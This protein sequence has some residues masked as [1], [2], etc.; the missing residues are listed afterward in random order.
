[1]LFFALLAASCTD[2]KSETAELHWT[3][4]GETGPEHWGNLE[5]EYALCET[6]LQQSPVNFNN[7]TANNALPILTFDYHAASGTLRSNGHAL[8]FDYP[9]GSKV[10][11][12]STDYTLK[13]FHFHTP[14]EHGLGLIAWPLE[15]HLV[16]QHADGKLVVVGVLFHESETES[17]FL[18]QF[19][20]KIE[21]ASL[22]VEVD[23]VNAAATLPSNKSYYAYEG[24][25]TTPPC[26]EGVTWR[27]L[28]TSIPASQEQLS[29][30]TR[31][32]IENSRPLQ[33][34]GSRTIQSSP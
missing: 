16:H 14:S 33:A 12:D 13:Q 32:F 28:R 7:A 24:S 8:Q 17:D 19:L 23:D 9:P 3:Y 18:A 4:S 10:S 1:M 11:I 20:E 31:V 30:I 15:M 29:A 27:V 22:E 2:E 6:G 21:M 34:L 25:L 5:P 26:S